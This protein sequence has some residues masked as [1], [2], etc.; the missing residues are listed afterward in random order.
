MPQST[1]RIEKRVFLRAS[2]ARVWDAIT[3]AKQFGTWFGAE[4]DGPFTE[5]ARLMGRIRP[6]QMDETVARS[7]EA[8][9]GT[10][11]EI[12]VER[13]EPQRRFRFRWHPYPVADGADPLTESMTLVAFDLEETEGGTLLTISE[14]G[15]DQVPLARRAE[16]FTS[17]EQGWSIQATLIE[18]YLSRAA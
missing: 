15:F 18:K 9:D 13:I 14:S 10:P 7:Q 11:F 16:A 1:D 3:D 4:F 5:G 12:I 6:T 17:N 2:R 8:Y